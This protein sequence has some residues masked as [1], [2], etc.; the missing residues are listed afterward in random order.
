MRNLF[1]PEELKVYSTDMDDFKN[2]T[3][4]FQIYVNVNGKTFRMEVYHIYQGDSMEKFKVKGGNRHIILQ[5]N[6]PYLK[7]YEKRENID[8]KLI[9]G[10]L[11]DANPKQ[12]SE[13]LLKIIEAIEHYI[14]D[15]PVPLSLYL[16]QKKN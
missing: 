7:R 5:S 9:E 8:W 11:S 16:Q 10:D 6:R 2:D 1:Q 4:D 15:Q 13:A 3:W 14:K 12:A